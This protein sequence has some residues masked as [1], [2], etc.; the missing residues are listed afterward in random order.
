MEMQVPQCGYC[1]PGLMMSACPMC[2]KIPPKPSA[3][4]WHFTFSPKGAY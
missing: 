4:Y 3:F 1:Q 2:P